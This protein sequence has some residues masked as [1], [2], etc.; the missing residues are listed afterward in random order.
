[1]SLGDVG[2]EVL[3]ILD[4]LI[5]SMFPFF[6]LWLGLLGP[7]LLVH[8]LEGADLFDNAV[9]STAVWTVDSLFAESGYRT[10]ENL[11]RRVLDQRSAKLGEPCSALWLLEENMG[12]CLFPTR[13]QSVHCHIQWSEK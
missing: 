9:G 3:R 12:A 1:L 8:D 13:S 5:K 6:T 10:R 4:R 7:P 2:F 11:P